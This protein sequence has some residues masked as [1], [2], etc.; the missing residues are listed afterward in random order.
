MPDLQTEMERAARRETPPGEMRAATRVLHASL[1]R[2]AKGA[3][4][5]LEAYLDAGAAPERA[6]RKEL[7]ELVDLAR[8]AIRT[9]E[10]W[11]G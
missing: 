2:L 7:R 6:P 3:V 11:V 1:I 9:W 5:T 10:S 8:Q 4:R